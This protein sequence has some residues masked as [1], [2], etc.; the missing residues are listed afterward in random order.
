[1]SKGVTEIARK[2]T[3]GGKIFSLSGHHEIEE[4]QKQLETLENRVSV[5]EFQELEKKRQ[6]TKKSPTE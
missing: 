3:T 1:M 2:G 6:R 5:L 4:L